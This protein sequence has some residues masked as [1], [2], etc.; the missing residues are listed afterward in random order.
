VREQV[1]PDAEPG[2]TTTTGAYRSP[3]D[4]TTAAV[5]ASEHSRI[6]REVG[7]TPTVGSEGHGEPE[8]RWMKS[9]GGDT[10]IDRLNNL[11]TRDELAERDV[12]APNGE[13]EERSDRRIQ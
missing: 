7:G 2:L 12:D 13:R 3:I 6:A 9:E 8:E 11:P 1:L 5:P 4:P 10:V